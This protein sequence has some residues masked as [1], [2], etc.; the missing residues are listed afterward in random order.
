LESSITITGDV[1]QPLNLRYD[2]SISIKDLVK[3]AGGLTISSDPQ[4]AE[5]FRLGF[6]VGQPPVRELL[7]VDL[8]KDMEPTSNDFGLQP[9]DVVVIR[10]TPEFGLQETISISGE[11]RKEGPFVLE[12]K[13]YHF[14]DLINDAG[15]FNQYADVYNSSLVRYSDIKGIIAFNAEEAMQNKG[16]RT[17][18]PVLVAGDYVV[19]PRLDNIVII[20]PNGTNYQLGE[21]QSQIN[22]AFQGVA[23]ARWYV[24]KFAG[25]FANRQDKK[26]FRVIR[27]NGMQEATKEWLIFRKH[28]K[29]RAGDIVVLSYK[30]RKG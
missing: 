30:R 27:Q 9:F 18:D 25:G 2:S 17:K 10:K 3:L 20:N 16:D 1:K 29:V 19:V 12:S 22:L 24:R 8:N 13:S 7:R 15:G 14:S 4:Y 26:Y 28:P 21:N 23:S 5:V 6:K 11:V